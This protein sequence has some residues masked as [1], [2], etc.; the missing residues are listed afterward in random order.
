MKC[1]FITDLNEAFHRRLVFG[2]WIK[3]KNVR[4]I[5][6]FN[7]IH[8]LKLSLMLPLGISEHYALFHAKIRRLE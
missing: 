7:L 8:I 5:K 1:S 2:R 6:T 3:P 4:K